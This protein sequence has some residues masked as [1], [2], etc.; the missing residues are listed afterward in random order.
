MVPRR[1][2][3][4]VGGFDL[5]LSTSADWDLFYRISDRHR[6]AFVPEILLKY[7][8]HNTNMH[9]NVGVMEHDMV[10]TFEKIFGNARTLNSR[11]AFGN[12]Y[13]IL[14][15]SYFRNHNYKQFV[16]CAGSSLR[17]HPGN[18]LYFLE[19]PF[20]KMRGGN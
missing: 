18:L 10:L 3:E 1:V 15:G 7:R 8:F 19:Y 2:F 4:E 17:Y 20:R 11:R 5:R 6:V 16:R 14:A 9:S 13:K 12:L